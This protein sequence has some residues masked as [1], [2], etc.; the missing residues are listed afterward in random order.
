MLASPCHVSQTRHLVIWTRAI[1]A[2]QL[3]RRW[4]VSVFKVYVK[5]VLV[6]EENDI[7]NEETPQGYIHCTV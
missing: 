4:L 3:N 1:E 6:L 5:K 7:S 2:N